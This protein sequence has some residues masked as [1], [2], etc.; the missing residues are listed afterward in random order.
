MAEPVGQ[1]PKFRR[2]ARIFGSLAAA[3]VGISLICLTAELVSAA[4][5][6]WKG[7]PIADTILKVTKQ[8]VLSAP[9][10]F[11]VV[12]LSRARRVFGRIA[13]GEVFVRAN[14]EGLTAIGWSLLMGA[15]WAIAVAGLEAVPPDQSIDH[16]LSA[17]SYSAAD[18]A[19]AALGLALIMIGRV[20]N[21]AATLKAENDGFV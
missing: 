18:L 12:G 20:M 19:L 3:A 5:P 1:Q 11:Y 17:I 6:L 16:I 15:L 8:A 2:Q 10:L 7:G 9:A 13:R 14:S 4:A 21:A